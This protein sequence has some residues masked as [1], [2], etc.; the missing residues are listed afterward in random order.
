MKRINNYETPEIMVVAVANEDI[1]TTS[2][3]SFSPV[4]DIFGG[5][6]VANDVDYGNEGGASN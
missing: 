1:L 4:V 3:G 6:E 2:P 5:A